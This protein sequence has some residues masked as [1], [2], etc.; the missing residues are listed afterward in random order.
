MGGV[1]WAGRTQRKGAWWGRGI[2]EGW[3]MG[4]GLGEL[5]GEV[6]DGWYGN[7]CGGVVE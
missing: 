5:D 3:V 7:G 6:M 4:R 2:M 1:Q